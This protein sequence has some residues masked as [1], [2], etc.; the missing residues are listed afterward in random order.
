MVP[1][2]A[3]NDFAEIALWLVAVFVLAFSYRHIREIIGF[4]LEK[5]YQFFIQ[6][7]V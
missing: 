5:L 4:L 6:N 1:A 3:N 2:A 7:H